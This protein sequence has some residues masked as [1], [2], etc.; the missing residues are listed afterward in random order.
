VIQIIF[1]L[2][3]FHVGCGLQQMALGGALNGVG[4]RLIGP[5]FWDDE[6][7]VDETSFDEELPSLR[8]RLQMPLV[9]GLGASIAS[10]VKNNVRYI[11]TYEGNVLI[12]ERFK[13]CPINQDGTSRLNETTGV[14]QNSRIGSIRRDHFIHKS[15]SV[16]HFVGLGPAVQIQRFR[17]CESDRQVTL[18]GLEAAIGSEGKLTPKHVMGCEWVGF[19]VGRK[20]ASQNI[21]PYSRESYFSVMPKLMD[22]YVG[23]LF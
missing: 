3:I 5:E 20:I 12:F 16:G 11:G 21:A 14:F 18:A 13:E 10:P 4:A 1:A 15:G 2:I 17:Y 7:E 9:L 19:F 8:L 23:V 6:S 22:C